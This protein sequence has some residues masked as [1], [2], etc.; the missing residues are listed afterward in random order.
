MIEDPRLKH[1]RGERAELLDEVSRRRNLAPAIL[2]KDYWVCL[3][4][5]AVFSLPD[6]GGHLVFKGGT[7][8]SKV[9][10]LIDRFPGDVHISFHRDRPGFG[11]GHDPEA[12]SSTHTPPDSR[13]R[14]NRRAPKGRRCFSPRLRHCPKS[15]KHSAHPSRKSKIYQIEIQGF[16]MRIHTSTEFHFQIALG[17]V[18]GSMWAHR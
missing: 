15:S 11:D 16:L 4:L 13:T 3:T 8:L 12:A 18:A 5:G 7:S 1:N 10:G 2:E 17:G 14:A 6:I 9:S